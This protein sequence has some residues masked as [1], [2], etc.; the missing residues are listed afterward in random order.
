MSFRLARNDFTAETLTG[1]AE[2]GSST[3]NVPLLMLSTVSGAHVRGSGYSAL[4]DHVPNVELIETRRAAPSGPMRILRYALSRPAITSWYQLGSAQ[5]EW[6]AWQ[7]LRQGF[8]GVVHILWADSD[9]G[10]LDLTTSRQSH[11]LCGTFH[12]PVDGLREAIRFP[13]RLRNFD[14]VI[15]MSETQR[16]FFL[17]FKVPAENIHVIPHGVNTA[18]FNPVGQ[19]PV[20]P[21]IVLAVG[22]YRRNFPLLHRVCAG[23]ESHSHIRVRIVASPQMRGMFAGLKN[24]EFM[25]GLTD[26][27]L[28]ATYH[29]ASCMVLTTEAA[30]ANNA[31][32][33]AIACGL[34]VVAEDVGGVREYVSSRCAALTPPRSA[35]A[36]IDAV[37]SLASSPEM[38]MRMG[39]AARERA[40]EFAWPIVAQTTMDLYER[41]WQLK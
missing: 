41:L 16:E 12:G 29:S 30:T 10:V 1:P 37:V 23:L 2:R 36:I 20:A 39:I 27:E 9:C 6:N 40:E 32:L 18:F 33:E 17:D 35:E 13:K 22:S 5:L 24:V 8:R 31:L 15:L 11:V 3:L 28:L 21:F 34:P 26:H 4:A 14:A 7:R 25:S 38:C 19:C